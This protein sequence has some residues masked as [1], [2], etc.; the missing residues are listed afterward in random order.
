[1]EYLAG[2]HGGVGRDEGRVGQG[3]VPGRRRDG[4]G[5]Q[6]LDGGRGLEFDA[7][8]RNVD[9]NVQTVV[10]LSDFLHVVVRV[11]DEGEGAR[12]RGLRRPRPHENFGRPCSEFNRPPR[13][14]RTVHLK[15][16]REGLGFDVSKLKNEVVS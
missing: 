9:L 4:A 13:Q 6:C 1:M 16:N 8:G 3:N 7:W 2:L 11:D 15:R 14:F 12:P 10:V 5:T